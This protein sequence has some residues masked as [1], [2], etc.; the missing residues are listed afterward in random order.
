[1]HI[2]KSYPKIMLFLASCMISYGL[3]LN[4]TFDSIVHVLN[5]D[6]YVSMFIGGMLFSFGFTTPFAIGLFVAASPSVNPF[7]GALVGGMGAVLSDLTIFSVARFTMSEELHRLSLTRMWHR[8]TMYLHRDH[9]P[10]YVRRAG[11]WLTAGLI[12]ASPLPDEI[13]VSMLS[14]IT[15]LDKRRFALL[16]CTF[17]T[18]GVLFVLL[19]AQ[20]IE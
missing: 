15:T 16:C 18:L 9:F 14:G 3:S 10:M 4:G 11:I 6:G 2:L 17:N 5:T 19:T 20:A 8:L 7:L 12:I 13:G 1:M